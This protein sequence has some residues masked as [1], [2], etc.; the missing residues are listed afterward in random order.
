ML[1]FLRRA[2]NND[3]WSLDLVL[4]L[5]LTAI[6]STVCQHVGLMDAS[7]SETRHV[8]YAT[9]AAVFASL[10]G[11]NVTSV[12]ILALVSKSDGMLKLRDER[13][14]IYDRLIGTFRTTIIAAIVAVIV[15][16]LAMI[17]ADPTALIA[18]V[19]IGMFLSIYSCAF[20]LTRLARSISRLFS[21][22][23]L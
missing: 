11:F 6:A 15:P 19:F 1:P 9:L 8:F 3:A 21:L 20:A 22:I 16:L 23:A 13:P 14:L 17:I 18:F 2:W 4:M 7:N 10:L 5:M 12:S